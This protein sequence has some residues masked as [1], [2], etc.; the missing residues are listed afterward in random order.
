MIQVTFNGRSLEPASGSLDTDQE[1]A[2]S[3]A[4]GSY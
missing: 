2:G 1:A 4:N 3:E